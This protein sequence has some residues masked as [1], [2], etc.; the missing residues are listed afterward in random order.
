MRQL[1]HFLIAGLSVLLI[2]LAGLATAQLNDRQKDYYQTWLKTADRAEEV[3]D[4]NRASNAALE[5]LRSE[6]DQYRDIFNTVRGQ[7]AERIHTLQ[8]Q[9]DAL[10]P[11][12]EDGSD[13]PGDIAALRSQLEEQLNELKVPRI[14]GEEAFSR[15][16]GLIN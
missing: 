15:A 7:N 9:L 12:P 14:I 6:I 1:R 13:E 5:N 10:G 4:E 11:K 3:V 16:N 2:G 8:S